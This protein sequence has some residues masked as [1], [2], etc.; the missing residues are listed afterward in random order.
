[1]K[2]IFVLLLGIIVF[3]ACKNNKAAEAK[4]NANDT[5]PFYPYTTN[6]KTQID[7]LTKRRV[8]FFKS[9]VDSMGKEKKEIITVTE[10]QQ[11]ASIFLN[12]NI[13]NQPLKSFYKENVFN[14]LTT[15]ST[16]MN[17]ST[18]IDSLIIKNVDVMLDAKNSNLL[19]RVNV[20]LMF[21][22]KDSTVTQNASWV[23]DKEFYIVKFIELPNQKSITQKTKVY[24][25]DKKI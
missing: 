17:Y 12:W 20:K 8:V 10:F 18:S 3:A 2:K 22:T 11:I 7:S 23:F 15:Q 24:W 4:E 5:V 6:I 19:K 21:Q 25:V 14:D 1:M 16:V 13:T 9:F